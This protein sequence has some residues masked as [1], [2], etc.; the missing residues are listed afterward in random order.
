ESKKDDPESD[1]DHHTKKNKVS[2]YSSSLSRQE[3]GKKGSSHHSDDESADSKKEGSRP[4]SSKKDRDASKDDEDATPAKKKTKV[5]EEDTEGDALSVKKRSKDMQPESKKHK[6]DDEDARPSKKKKDA[7]DEERP[8]KKSKDDA[9]ERPS[10]K[11]KDDAEEERPSKKSK[12]DEEA[13]PV[14]KNKKEEDEPSKGKKDKKVQAD[15]GD[16]PS[17]KKKRSKPCCSEELATSVT[18]S[19]LTAA[20]PDKDHDKQRESIR[21]R[22]NMTTVPK[23]HVLNVAPPFLGNHPFLRFFLLDNSANVKNKKLGE[24]LEKAALLVFYLRY[25]APELAPEEDDDDD[26]E[27]EQARKKKE[28]ASFVKKTESDPFGERSF[29]KQFQLCAELWK[30]LGNWTNQPRFAHVADDAKAFADDALYR[31]FGEKPAVGNRVS[32]PMLLLPSPSGAVKTYYEDKEDVTKDKAA[33]KLDLFADQLHDFGWGPSEVIK[34]L[35]RCINEC[36][37][38]QK[39]VSMLFAPN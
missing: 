36:V 17:K 21:T 24:T 13:R 16:G 11:K 35:E 12:E 15:E 9:E 5:L 19:Y 34:A 3:N 23:G 2:K 38:Y 33:S 18:K 26:D 7:T 31:I 4:S 8:S 6:D 30:K 27:E 39:P 28:A 22:P 32:L 25:V 10:K 1:G 29:I 14:K 37:V 20:T